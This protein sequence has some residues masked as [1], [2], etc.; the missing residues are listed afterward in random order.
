[1]EAPQSSIPTRKE[2]TKLLKVADFDNFCKVFG[3]LNKVHIR[4]VP[5]LEAIGK[6]GIVYLDHPIIGPVPCFAY[7]DKNLTEYQ[8]KLVNSGLGKDE[9]E[10]DV[11][12]QFND[13]LEAKGF[14]CYAIFLDTGSKQIIEHKEYNCNDCNLYSIDGHKD[15]CLY[16]LKEIENTNICCNKYCNCFKWQEIKEEN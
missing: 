16:D 6:A 13:K 8:Y 7:R 14:D 9:V 2:L 3:E 4:K 11:V 15:V 1:M 10:I 5:C 12:K